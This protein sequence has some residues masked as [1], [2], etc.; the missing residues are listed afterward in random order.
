MANL[1]LPFSFSFS[2]P[3]VPVVAVVAVV[4][5]VADRSNCGGCPLGSIESTRPRTLTGE[6][7]IDDVPD[8]WLTALEA[9]LADTVELPRARL[10]PPVKRLNNDRFRTLGSSRD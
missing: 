6:F 4:A 9:D 5:A 8:P 2:L 7:G 10:P 3:F 1:I